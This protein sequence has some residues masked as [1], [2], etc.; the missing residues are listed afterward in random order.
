MCC[1][2]YNIFENMHESSW[3]TIAS[4][5]VAV[6]AWMFEKPLLVQHEIEDE[7]INKLLVSLSFLMLCFIPSIMVSL[8]FIIFDRGDIGAW[9]ITVV[10]SILILI[11][12]T[13]LLPIKRKDK[14]LDRK[15]AESIHENI[16]NKKSWFEEGAK[17]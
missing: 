14:K 4:I 13:M 16:R 17:Q 11:P 1:I 12:L 3:I 10:L 2:P 5:M 9:I 8:L 7:F 15:L 6:L